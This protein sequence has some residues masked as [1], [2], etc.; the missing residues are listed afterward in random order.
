MVVVHSARSTQTS[1]DTVRAKSFLLAPRAFD[2]FL[3][4]QLTRFCVGKPRAEVP[5][6]P[7]RGV[8]LTAQAGVFLCWDRACDAMGIIRGVMPNR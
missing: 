8:R 1:K 2:G 3:A 5:Q 6:R 4:K 7:V